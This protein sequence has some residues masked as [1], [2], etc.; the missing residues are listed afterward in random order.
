MVRQRYCAVFEVKTKM[1]TY[2]FCYDLA[3]KYK[4]RIEGPGI[5]GLKIH[6]T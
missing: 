1:L 6:K 2:Y 4:V 3:H 5:P